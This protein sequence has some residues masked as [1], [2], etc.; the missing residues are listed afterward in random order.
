[1]YRAEHDDLTA[2]AEGW[3]L[4]AEECRPGDTWET[5][6]RKCSAELLARLNDYADTSLAAFTSDEPLKPAIVS[7]NGDSHFCWVLGSD[8]SIHFWNRAYGWQRVPSPF[9][10]EPSP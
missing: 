7:L 6:Y 3:L 4:D 9:D 10:A 1:M 2:L 8:D 5:V